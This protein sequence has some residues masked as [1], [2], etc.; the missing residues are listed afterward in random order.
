MDV[1]DQDGAGDCVVQATLGALEAILLVKH[2][3][4]VK[5][6][7]NCYKESLFRKGLISENILHPDMETEEE[8]DEKV[9]TVKQA[10]DHLM[11]E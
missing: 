11:K 7:M 9:P 4:K 1:K 6:S 8:R 5:L 3:L 10:L 2:N